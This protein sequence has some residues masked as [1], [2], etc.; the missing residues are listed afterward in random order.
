MSTM[1][2]RP[3]RGGGGVDQQ[4]AK[5]GDEVKPRA[6]SETILRRKNIMRGGGWDV[7]PGPPRSSSSGPGSRGPAWA[8]AGG[9]GAGGRADGGDSGGAE[10]EG[11]PGL[12]GGRL[13]R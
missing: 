2:T 3:L 11:E 8:W 5:S 7:L 6:G 4:S 1:E 12:G 10:G 13:H 9:L